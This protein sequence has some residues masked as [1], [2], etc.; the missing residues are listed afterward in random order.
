MEMPQG[1]CRGESWVIS[2]AGLRRDEHESG[3]L[4]TACNVKVP[5]S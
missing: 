4:A 2:E 1:Q 5:A 3:A